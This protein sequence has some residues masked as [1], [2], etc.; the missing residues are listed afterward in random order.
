MEEEKK[1]IKISFNMFIAIIITLIII[2][3]TLIGFGIFF[4]KKVN[5]VENK[6][7]SDNKFSYKN[8]GDKINYSVTV[9]DIKLDNWRLFYYNNDEVYVIYEGYLPNSTNIAS[10]VGLTQ[11]EDVYS[12]YG[13][14]SDI[15]KK[16]F[17]NKLNAV[18]KKDLWDD[19]L[20]PE[21]K[22][23]GATA[24]GGID[25]E[26]WVKSWNAKGY[27]ELAIDKTEFSDGT[28]GYSVLKK[29][30]INNS[31]QGML[32]I[33][34][35]TDGYG[36]SLYF[37][38]INDEKNVENPYYGYWI[39]SPSSMADGYLMIATDEGSLGDNLHGYSNAKGVGIRPIINIPSKIL[40]KSEVRENTWD[41]KY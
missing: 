14:Y 33:S 40:Q 19:L 18:R 3:A 29:D 20:T 27:V 8:I 32:N 23:A 13:V 41:I 30:N 21:L 28:E 6:I 25:I 36:D 37:P 31:T 2:V 1:V 38:L 12:E 5:N 39:A 11:G 26:T 22:K 7:T 24:K 10:K 17:L 35:D 9:N 4:I 34:S 16:D 15:S